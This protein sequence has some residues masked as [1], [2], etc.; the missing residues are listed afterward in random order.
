MQYGLDNMV[1]MPL[2]HLSAWAVMDESLSPIFVLQ[3]ER[4]LVHIVVHET[5]HKAHA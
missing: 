2:A 1:A 5:Q 3:L 4:D